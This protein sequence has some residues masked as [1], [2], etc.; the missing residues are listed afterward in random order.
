MTRPQARQMLTR[1]WRWIS[2]EGLWLPTTKLFRHL[3]GALLVSWTDSC[4][5]SF[6]ESLGTGWMRYVCDERL[7]ASWV[8][9]GVLQMSNI[10]SPRAPSVRLITANSN[11]ISV[12]APSTGFKRNSPGSSPDRIQ[13]T[14]IK[15]SHSSVS[16]VSSHTLFTRRIGW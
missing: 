7:G 14:I 8:W 11:L 6:E 15:S 13:G 10:Q 1:S 5:R 2:E 3:W 4:F 9:W 16:S 12:L